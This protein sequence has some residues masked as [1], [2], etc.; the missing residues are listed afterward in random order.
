MNK[1][2]NISQNK[3]RIYFTILVKLSCLSVCGLCVRPERKIREKWG[4]RALKRARVG[5]RVIYLVTH[6]LSLSNHLIIHLTPMT[7]TLGPCRLLFW[8]E[9]T[10]FS[11]VLFVNV[12]AS[13]YFLD[14]T[15]KYV[16]LLSY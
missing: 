12:F 3:Q 6:S 9:M 15:L 16:S 7:G 13:A 1:D 5:S 14:N 11:V 10:P 2:G 4:T 8:R